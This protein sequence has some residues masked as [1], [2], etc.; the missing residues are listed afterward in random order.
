MSVPRLN[1]QLVLQN[2]VRMPDGAGGFTISWQP[3]GTLWAEVSAR[4]GRETQGE[5]VPLSS[6]AYKIRLRASPIGHEMRPKPE[7]R[8]VEGSRVFRIEAVV[9]DDLTGRF[10]TCLAQEEVVA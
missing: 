4:T 3:L 9:E 6:V 10:L 8:F 1:R 7:Q 2:P 5:A